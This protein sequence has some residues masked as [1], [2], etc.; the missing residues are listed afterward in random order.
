M[1]TPELEAK[2]KELEAKAKELEAK[3]K[4]LEAKAKKVENIMLE[5]KMQGVNYYENPRNYRA[6]RRSGWRHC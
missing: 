4:E 6:K 3:A 2:A 5:L 1:I